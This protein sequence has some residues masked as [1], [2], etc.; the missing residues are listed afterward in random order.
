MR[1]TTTT[2]PKRATTTTA[3]KGTTST[4]TSTTA[5]PAP[6]VGVVMSRGQADVDAFPAGT[7][8]CVSG[9]HAWT[10]RPKDGNVFVGPATLDGQGSLRAAF[11]GTAKNVTL[12]NL[13]IVRY[14]G[15]DQQGA[16]NPDDK[17]AASGWTLNDLEVADNAHVGVAPG[18][19]WRINGGRFH[20][21]GQEGLGGAVGDGVTVDGAEIDHNNFTDRTYTRRKVSCGYEAGGFKWVADNVTV[22]NSRI[23]HNA[24]K[25]LWADLNS[26][27]STITGNVVHDNWDE[28]I[29]IEISSYATITGNVVYG[30]G[31]RNYNGDGTGCPWLFG[32]GITVNSSDHVTIAH[33]QVTDNC[34]G[35]T[36]VQQDRPDGDPGLLQHLH[37]H[38]NTIAGSGLSGIAHDD[39]N[40]GVFSRCNNRFERN[41]FDGGIFVWRDGETPVDKV[42]AVGETSSAAECAH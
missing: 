32:G 29:F 40:D 24:C 17:H 7:T 4:S 33:N 1:R 23:H 30:N 3:P 8:F 14:N 18:D 19:G 9:T 12:T 6:C 38:D 21:N 13:R 42:G 2:A 31:K 20:H 36:A 34:N 25:G 37:V 35:I 16:I 27:N 22:R 5:P 15:G 39:G 41:R 10:L 11:V 26:R 28:G